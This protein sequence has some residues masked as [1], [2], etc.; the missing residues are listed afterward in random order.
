M[1]I[2]SRG[3]VGK[4]DK[5]NTVTNNSGSVTIK[6][7]VVSTNE[8]GKLRTV[9]MVERRQNVKVNSITVDQSVD[10]NELNDIKTSSQV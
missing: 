5:G 4:D 3:L 8:E 9:V 1:V 2:L 7:W 6:D 10:L